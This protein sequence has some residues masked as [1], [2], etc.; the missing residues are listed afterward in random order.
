MR[1]LSGTERASMTAIQKW[2]LSLIA[3]AFAVVISY[4]WI[5]RPVATLVSRYVS[6]REQLGALTKGFDPLAMAAVVV[7]VGLG[8]FALSERH[9]PRRL[10]AALLCSISLI[11]TQ[12][13]KNQLKFAFGRTWPATWVDNNLSFI[14][15]GVYGFNFF[16]GGVGYSSFPSG[17]SAVAC[18]VLSIF[19]II[20][21]KFRP[22]Y[23]LAMFAVTAA[24]VG[25]NLHFLSDVIA[26]A[27]VGIST[28][29]I[30]ATLW[31]RRDLLI[32]PER[33]LKRV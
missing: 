1:P 10:T 28:A 19:W 8:L 5:D 33:P 11:L 13:V 25:M 9:L 22:F 31:A 18:A 30:T 7:F 27:F 6:P 4:V 14:R 29:W 3:C 26:G 20:Y 17:H 24:L 12:A 32:S 15:D 2:S 16:H 21:P 23:I